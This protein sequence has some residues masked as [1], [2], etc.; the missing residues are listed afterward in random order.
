MSTTTTGRIITASISSIKKLNCDEIWQITRSDK[1]I[2]GNKWVSELAPGWDLFNQYLH[3]WKGKPPEEW[4]HLCAQAYNEELQSEVKL[5]ALRRLWSLVNY[6][7]V[8]GLVCFCPVDRYCHRRLVAEFLHKH[9]I[10]AEEY[11][12]P[13]SQ[14]DESVVQ[15]LLF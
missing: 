6:G 15:A 9:G 10:V 4:W 5:A 7:K 3:N 13:A 8:I 12:D 1:V 11:S 2:T 14:R